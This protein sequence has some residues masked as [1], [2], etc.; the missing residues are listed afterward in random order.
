MKRITKKFFSL[1]LAL[2][3]AASLAACS[4]SAPQPPADEPAQTPVN[5]PAAASE[6]GAKPDD[7]PTKN[8]SWIVPVAAGSPTDLASRQLADALQASIGTNISVENVTGGNQTIGINDALS[9]GSDGYTI[10]SLANAGL[11]TQPLMNPDIGYGLG[12]IKLIAMITPACMATITVPVDS[13][14]KTYD[15]FVAFVTSHDEFSYAVPNSGGYGHLSILSLLGQIEGASLGKAIAYDGN[16]GAYQALLTGEVDF[17]ISDDNFIYTH[18]NDGECNT[19]ACLA[20]APSYYLQDVPAVGDYGIKNMDALA[21]WK[22]VGVNADT[23][24]EIVSYL[25]KEIDGI[26]A[27]DAYAEYL[28]NSGCGS[29]ASIQDSEEITA[30]VKDAFVLYEEILTSAGLM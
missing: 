1:C 20:N 6:P 14:I 12:D 10:F 13:D 4:K 26:L 23:P 21:G 17:A 24:D 8:I 30:L 9:R 22:I 29:F 11:I 5:E 7:Y 2:V 15:D 19:I 28:L 25:T 16:N 27:S 3:L 18:Y